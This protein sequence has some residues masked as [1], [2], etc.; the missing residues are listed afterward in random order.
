MAIT[1]DATVAGTATNS[2]V[3]VAEADDYFSVYIYATGQSEWP[4][5]SSTATV[6]QKEKYLMAATRTID[7]QLFINEKYTE[8][9]ALQF[10]RYMQDGNTEDVDVI[11]QAIKNAV[12]EEALGI[13]NGCGS[14]AQC[15]GVTS[16][17]MGS[18]AVTYGFKRRK[19]ISAKAWEYLRDWLKR[20]ND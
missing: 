5:G 11:P 14:T 19:T 10:P 2:Y 4:S 16:E 12:F 13:I 15:D 20:R 18:T 3:T 9:Q 1:F 6:T 7:N 17:R 8:E